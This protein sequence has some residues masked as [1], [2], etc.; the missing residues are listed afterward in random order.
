MF[1]KLN[2]TEIEEVLTKQIFGRIACHADNLT[3]IVPTSYAYDG[4]CIYGR[5]FEVL[6]ID[7]IRKNQRVCF[8][9][10]T[11]ENMAN[12]KSVI[13][14]GDFKELTV[15]SE[16]NIALEKLLQRKVPG[17]ASKTLQLSP[18]WPFS[19]SQNLDKIEGIIYCIRLTE[20]T[21]RFEKSDDTIC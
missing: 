10:D 1:G 20:K 12:W 17:I 11:M 18:L 15:S 9:T 2:N 19:T 4:G 16:R 21:G 3:Y 13:A 6:K 5:T 8:Q 7:L 14:W